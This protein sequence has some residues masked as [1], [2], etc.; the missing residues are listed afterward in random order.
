MKVII[1]YFRKRKEIKI[2]KECRFIANM[3]QIN[4]EKQ[5]SLGLEPVVTAYYCDDV[6]IWSV[7]EGVF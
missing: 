5:L 6:K 4:Y 1:N 2:R 3:A 7:D